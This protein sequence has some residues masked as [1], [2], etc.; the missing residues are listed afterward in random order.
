MLPDVSLEHGEEFVD[1]FFIPKSGARFFAHRGGG[2]F[3][4]ERGLVGP[5]GSQ[6]VVHID[7]LQDAR[8][9]R[10]FAFLQTVGITGTIRVFMMVADDRQHKPQR[11]QRLADIFPGEGC[12]FMIS[13]S[14][15]VRLEPFSKFHRA[16]AILPRS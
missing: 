6:C 8:Q 10:D 3:V 9:Q 1:E 15:G 4:I 14:N 12:F 2:S 16:L 5:L 13:H 11:L 7:D